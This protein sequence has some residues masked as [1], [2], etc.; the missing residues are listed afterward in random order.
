MAGR[1]FC[2][3]STWADFFDN[4]PVSVIPTGAED[5]RNVTCLMLAAGLGRSDYVRTLLQAGAD[6]NRAT[7]R[8][9]AQWSRLSKVKSGF[10][11]SARRTRQCAR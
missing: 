1:S 3:K 2:Q 11:R 5:D 8:Y 4:Y 10:N 6:R 9:T 7:G